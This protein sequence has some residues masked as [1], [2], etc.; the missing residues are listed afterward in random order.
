MYIDMYAGGTIRGGGGTRPDGRVHPQ[1]EGTY[2]LVDQAACLGI[3]WS[4]S[5]A[6]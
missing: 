4:I 6:P 2:A 5:S 3:V 1:H